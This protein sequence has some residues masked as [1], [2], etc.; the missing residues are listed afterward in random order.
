MCNELEE[1]RIYFIATSQNLLHGLL[2]PIYGTLN[3][4]VKIREI[5]PSR[6]H[7]KFNNTD[8]AVKKIEE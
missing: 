7:S 4:G 3:I 6:H 2:S 1:R 8:E 5:L